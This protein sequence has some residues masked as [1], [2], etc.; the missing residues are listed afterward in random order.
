MRILKVGIIVF[1]FLSNQLWAQ[2]YGNYDK[3]PFAVGIFPPVSSN[4]MNAGNCVNQFSLNLISGYS[5][6]LTGFE[7]AGFS[8]TERDFVRGVQYAGF[9]NFVNGDFTGFQFSGFGNF[10]RDVSRGF[11]F[12][13]FANFNYDEAN[14]VL[15]AGFANF[16][17]GKSLAIQLSGFANFCED[18]QGVQATGFANVVKGDGKV[19][20]F[21]GFSN[22]ILGEVNGIQAAGFLNFSKAKMQNLQAA[23]FC[24]VSMDDVTGL[25]LAGFSNI[26]NG[27]L[28]GTQIAGFVNVAKKVNGL[29]LGFINIADTIESG[30]PLGFLSLVRKG[31]RELE[32]SVGEGLNAQLA[33]KIGVNQF[34]NIFAIGA[35]FLGTG[36][37]WGVGYGIG[38][39]L[40]NN[41]QT[42]VQLELM[43]YHLY[44][45]G[46]WTDH[47]NGLEQLK[48]TVAKSLGNHL[49]V[50]A[51]PTVNLLIT[52]HDGSKWQELYS[53]FASYSFYSR[54][55][56]HNSMKGWIGL[57]AGIR[58]N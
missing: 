20:Q 35:Q 41:D 37:W 8:N 58:F 1:L 29:Q 43:S 51:G 27:N 7:F 19:F 36:D 11:Q 40:L 34:Y 38:T 15:A 17:R 4:G 14:G 13:G 49:R 16:T 33:F 45:G 26:A 21:S 31:F 50:F 28:H 3:V 55:G 6:G 9:F 52:D 5:A 2:S 32:F 53:D 44:E 23:G 54:T 42:K 24:N 48:L 18:V 10:N 57:T 46:N 22:I 47:Y 39:H 56:K 25:Q 30:V 12:S